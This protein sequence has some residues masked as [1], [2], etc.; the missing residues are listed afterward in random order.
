MPDIV[1][2]DKEKS[3]WTSRTLRSHLGKI[4]QIMKLRK[5]KN[6]VFEMEELYDLKTITILPMIFLT[7]GIVEKHLMKN[8]AYL[9]FERDIINALQ[10]RLSHCFSHS[11]TIC[12]I[13]RNYNY[14]HKRK[15]LGL[16]ELQDLKNISNLIYLY[17]T[18]ICVILVLDILQIVVLRFPNLGLISQNP[19]YDPL[20][21]PFRRMTAI[22]DSFYSPCDISDKPLFC[23]LF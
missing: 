14:T 3:M 22:F 20:N 23:T 21:S 12:H 4:Y 5:Y 9:V 19:F 2:I 17:M 13:I 8:T 15:Q 11:Q 10:K 1:L 7:N 18:T 6:P 16:D